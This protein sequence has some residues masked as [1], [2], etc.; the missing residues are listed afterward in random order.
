MANPTIQAP[1]NPSWAHGK[2]AINRGNGARCW[3]N[4]MYYSTYIQLHLLAKELSKGMGKHVH[5]N[6]ALHHA[7]AHTLRDINGQ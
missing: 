7:V 5:L 4:G 2:R 3:F 1:A 6:A